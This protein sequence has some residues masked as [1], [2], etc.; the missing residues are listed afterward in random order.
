MDWNNDD[1]LEALARRG[2]DLIGNILV[3]AESFERYQTLRH[4]RLETIPADR[5]KDHYV[6]HAQAAVDGQTAGSSAG[7]EHPKIRRCPFG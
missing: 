2:E 7:G 6:L 4:S 5:P 3:G 1:I